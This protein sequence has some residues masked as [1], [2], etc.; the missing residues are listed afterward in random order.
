M[1]RKWARTELNEHVFDAPLSPEAQYWVG[2]LMADGSVGFTGPNAGHIVLAL[3]ERDRGHVEA[4][5]RFLGSTHAIYA[6]APAPAP[7]GYTST[8]LAQLKV[9]SADLVRALERYGVVPG[10]S[11]RTRVLGLE[12]SRDFWR[13]VVDGD[14]SVGVQV[15][16]RSKGVPWLALA[17]SPGLLEQ[18]VHFVHREEPDST[19]VPSIRP[20]G[21]AVL[22]YRGP[23]AC[24]I[25]RRLYAGAAVAL[26]RKLEAA[27]SACR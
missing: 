27:R 11:R 9:E 7:G 3:Q 6:R 16:G 24:R 13:G 5:R 10:K 2:F 21:L 20:N 17:G 8:G 22:T 26:P 4:F 25:L 23:M 18:F 19:Q 12:Q 1:P 14:G 15:T